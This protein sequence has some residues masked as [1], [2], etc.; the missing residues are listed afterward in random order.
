MHQDDTYAAFKRRF[1]TG[2]TTIDSHTAG[3][4][5]RLVVEGLGPIP[6][7]TMAEKRNFTIHNLDRERLLLTTEPRGNRDVVAALMTEPTTPGAS[8][9]LIYM[10]ARRYPYLCGH[11]TIGAVTTLLETGMIKAFPDADG[12]LRL[13]VD[14]PSG[15]MPVL[16]KMR[17]GRV[18]SVSFTSVPCFTYA[19]NISLAVPGIGTVCIDLVCA[20]GFFAMVD[21]SQP[22]FE[23]L[24][25]SHDQIIRLGMDIT[26]LASRHLDVRHPERDEVASI[27][28]TEFYRTK[29]PC[30]GN[31]FV[32]YGES[33]LDRSPCGTGTSAKMALLYS[34][35]L[36]SR[37][38][39][40]ENSGPL[41]TSFKARIVQ[42]TMVGE[43]RAVCVEV[44]G[45]AHVTGLHTFVLDKT[46][47]F[48]S[49]FLL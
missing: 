12:C 7:R 1:P 9:G 32:V 22:L 20:G 29:G 6:G 33:H 17:P 35:G 23:S 46:D 27:D 26:A 21:L 5:T 14:T 10:D 16:V 8:F 3:E 47:P 44:T 49:G 36:V 39:V 15:P 38:A 31:S 30:Q 48:P 4:Y 45:S 37:D 18:D 34:R 24:E 11:A 43:Y 19:R 13:I 42:E 40:Y 25:L 28:V 41:G 2:I